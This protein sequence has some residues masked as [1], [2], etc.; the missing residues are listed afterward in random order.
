MFEI[1]AVEDEKNVWRVELTNEYGEMLVFDNN[2]SMLDGL[3]TVIT[4]FI[5]KCPSY[6]QEALETMFEFLKSL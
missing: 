1:N 3:V 6:R 5:D 2:E 4:K